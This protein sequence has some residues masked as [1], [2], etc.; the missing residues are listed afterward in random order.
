MNR[1]KTAR[2]DRT[3]KDLRNLLPYFKD[4]DAW[5]R[6]VRRLERNIVKLRRHRFTKLARTLEASLP[7]LKMVLNEEKRV[8][9]FTVNRLIA[10]LRRE[11]NL[12][13]RH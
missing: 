1:G 10:R 6:E 11:D 2:L 4:W 9:A 5:Q 8:H 7:A 3:V 12:D 13:H